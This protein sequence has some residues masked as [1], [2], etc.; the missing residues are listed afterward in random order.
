MQKS[1]VLNAGD[2]EK[3]SALYITKVLVL[4]TLRP[5]TDDSEAEYVFLQYM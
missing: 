5:P 3:E 4:L 1:S 2:G